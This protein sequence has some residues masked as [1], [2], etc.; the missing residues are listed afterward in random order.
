MEHVNNDKNS[1]A[2]ELENVKYELKK[3]NEDLCKFKGLED[4]LELLKIQNSSLNNEVTQL[5]G[6]KEK[7]EYKFN[8]GE[9]Q[10]EKLFRMG[11]AHRDMTGLDFYRY[12]KRA[13]NSSTIF[14]KVESFT[15]ST[16][17]SPSQVTC[18][19]CSGQGHFKFE[20][21]L[22]KNMRPIPLNEHG[23]EKPINN[24]EKSVMK[25]SPKSKQVNT[26][27]KESAQKKEL[28]YLPL[29][30]QRMKELL[31]EVEKLNSQFKTHM[32]KENQGK[33]IKVNIYL[34]LKDTLTN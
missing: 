34:L 31:K 11:K 24:K 7:F 2:K 22:R 30:T 10:F 18:Y 17:P 13:L 14:V 12:I 8:H 1:L 32:D 28:A 9:E 16:Q 4:E 6:N 19:Y 33:N 25:D 15:S 26:Y 27:K 21:K 5:K 23:K 3:A 20:F 29:L